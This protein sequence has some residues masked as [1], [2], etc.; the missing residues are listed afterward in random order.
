VF[1]CN[2]EERLSHIQQ[3]E[4]AS[5]AERMAKPEGAGVVGVS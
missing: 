2:N 5:G 3:V 1:W 4:A